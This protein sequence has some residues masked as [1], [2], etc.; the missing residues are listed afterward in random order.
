MM[1]TLT[2]MVE[3][4]DVQTIGAAAVNGNNKVSGAI[5]YINDKRWYVSYSHE[6][7][8]YEWDNA[9]LY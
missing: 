5:L 9:P 2:E 8:E 6:R 3:Q 1:L 4:F 7:E